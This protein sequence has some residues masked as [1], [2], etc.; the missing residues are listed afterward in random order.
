MLLPSDRSPTRWSQDYY[1]D[2]DYYYPTSHYRVR[3]RRVD[4]ELSSLLLEPRGDDARAPHLQMYTG[5]MQMDVEV[6]TVLEDMG[7]KDSTL[8]HVA[9]H[10]VD[11]RT[12][13]QGYEPPKPVPGHPEMFQCQGEGGRF[14]MPLLPYIGPWGRS[15][16]QH[17]AML[18]T[19]YL[20]LI[21]HPKAPEL[22]DALEKSNDRFI[23]ETLEKHGSYGV[24][25]VDGVL[26][27]RF[28]LRRGPKEH[29]PGS[30]CR[31]CALMAL[32]LYFQHVVQMQGRISL[33]MQSLQEKIEVHVNTMLEDLRVNN[34]AYVYNS[35]RK[36][37]EMEDV[38]TQRIRD[39]GRRTI[40]RWRSIVPPFPTPN[41]MP[42]FAALLSP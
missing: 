32:D 21:S 22:I 2:M 39:S 13:G 10:F 18:G 34:S 42:C 17:L 4:D 9:Q 35:P 3:R 8:L 30:R 25:W 27:S 36:R 23:E 5:P 41:A 14:F 24:D 6:S 19:E 12:E 20:D 40:S 11:L 37:K 29:I 28:C 33:K 7:R 38:V 1:S 31:A 26:R 15:P 16:K